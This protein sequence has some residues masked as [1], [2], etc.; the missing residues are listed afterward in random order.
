[1]PNPDVPNLP[2]HANQPNST[3]FPSLDGGAPADDGAQDGRDITGQWLPALN[4]PEPTEDGDLPRAF[5]GGS[6]LPSTGAPPLSDPA[7]SP[8]S[9]EATVVLDQPPAQRRPRTVQDRINR[10][11][12]QWRQAEE[13]KSTLEQQLSTVVQK[14][15]EQD[16]YIRDLAA[17]RSPTS[18]SN[19]TFDPAAPPPSAGQP[20]VGHSDRQLTAEEVRGIVTG[21][22]NEFAT[23]SIEQNRQLAA[24]QAAHDESFREAVEEFP[25][26]A[27]TRTSARQ[28]FDRL[29][30]SSPL[31]AL[32]NAPYQIALQV[33]GILVGEGRQAAPGL[34][35]ED[36][37][38]AASVPVARP[39]PQDIPDSQRGAYQQEFE[40]LGGQIRAGDSSFETYRK[41]R[42][43]RDGLQAKR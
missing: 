33:Q 18:M 30:A 34:G 23:K 22:I 21:A 27:D 6:S 26:L 35:V 15:Q 1:M 37:K 24:L 29:Y 40:R 32:P 7:A 16:R 42:R 8:A 2:V 9:R 38:R 36:R 28:L 13:Q 19:P 20:P 11:T 10:L 3:L 17:G 39:T 25:E 5:T 43:L 41:W 31:R 4:E 12:K 14:L